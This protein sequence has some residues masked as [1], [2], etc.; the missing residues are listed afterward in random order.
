MAF[1]ASSRV[2]QVWKS[3]VALIG[4]R[5]SFAS[6]LRCCNTSGRI[7][8]EEEEID[9]GRLDDALDTLLLGG[10]SAVLLGTR[11]CY[12]VDE[13]YIHIPPTP[14]WRISTPTKTVA[15]VGPCGCVGGG[16]YAV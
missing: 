8:R 2:G 5:S 7:L 1:I 15:I 3:S 16:V 4:K 9:I 12:M 14:L 10:G 11:G 6:A 13:E